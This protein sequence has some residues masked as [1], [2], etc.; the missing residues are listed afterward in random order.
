MWQK[1]R[2]TNDLHFVDGSETLHEL[3]SSCIPNT[4][5]ISG[6]ISKHPRSQVVIAGVRPFQQDVRLRDLFAIRLRILFAKSFSAFYDL[7][8][9]QGWFHGF[10]VKCF[11]SFAPVQ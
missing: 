11:E 10:N 9:Q 3:I 7:Q 8:V 1:Y 5:Y 6:G 2:R 4:I